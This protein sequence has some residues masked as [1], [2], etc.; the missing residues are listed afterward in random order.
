M[1]WPFLHS[2]WAPQ[3]ELRRHVCVPQPSSVPSPLTKKPQS[4]GPSSRLKTRIDPYREKAPDED[5]ITGQI[6]AE[7][8]RREARLDEHAEALAERNH[9]RCARHA[10]EQRLRR[11][12]ARHA[13]EAAE[14]A[15]EPARVTDFATDVAALFELDRGAK[16]E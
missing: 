1:H 2:M 7:R 16:P 13:D 8:E 10:A 5:G 4:T 3:S 6:A 11:D 9:E 14:T 12:R 15:P